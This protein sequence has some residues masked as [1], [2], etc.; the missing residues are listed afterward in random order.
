MRDHRS[1]SIAIAAS[2]LIAA[3]AL[4]GS[5]AASAA[6]KIRYSMNWVP[7][8]EH[9]GFYQAKATG[10]YDK[11]GLDVIKTENLYS[12]DGVKAFTVAQGQ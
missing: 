4:A 1:T 2:A 10:L 6:E 3:G 12:F 7:E 11:A 9:C 8:G 5:T